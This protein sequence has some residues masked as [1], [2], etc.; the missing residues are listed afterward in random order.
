MWFNFH[1][2]NVSSYAL[3]R[4]I[5]S[6]TFSANSRLGQ[7]RHRVFAG[8]TESKEQGHR[9]HDQFVLEM[10]ADSL[11]VKGLSLEVSFYG[12]SPS[13]P[14]STWHFENDGLILSSQKIFLPPETPSQSL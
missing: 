8:G 12:V 3:P 14:G 6:I 11:A 7:V 13:Q 9:F 2:N 5:F 1:R 10:M 4:Q